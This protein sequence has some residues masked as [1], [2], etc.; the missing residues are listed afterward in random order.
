MPFGQVEGQASLS[1]QMLL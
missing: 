1:H